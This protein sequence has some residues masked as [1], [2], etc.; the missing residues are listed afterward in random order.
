MDQLEQALFR[1][2][3]STFEE[4]GFV[5]PAETPEDGDAAPV[6]A[7]SAEVRF[8]GPRNGRLSIA[9]EERLLGE[10]AANMLGAEGAISEETRRDALGEI[11]NVLCGNLLP[12]IGGP[13]GRFKIEAP[14]IVPSEEETLF[15]EA[16]R[17]ILDFDSGR[18]EAR[19]MLE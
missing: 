9:V 11:A 18:A 4:L 8:T 3:V 7:A 17:V 10:I 6:E 1:T 15:G 2:T 16:I 14:V 12:E 5:V 13:G 19:L